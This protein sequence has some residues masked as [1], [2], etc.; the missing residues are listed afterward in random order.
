VAKGPDSAGVVRLARSVGGEATLGNHDAHLLRYRRAR[1]DGDP[2]GDVSEGI[3]KIAKQLDDDDWAWLESLR[4][5]IALPEHAA[6]VV[7]AGL[8]PGV[9]IDRQKQDDMLTMR[10][11]RGDGTATKRIDEGEPWA[12]LW[13]GPPHVY[14]GHDAV[15]GLQ[16][17]PH[18]TGLDTACVYGGRLSACLLPEREIVSVRARRVYSEP[19]KTIAARTAADSGK[20]K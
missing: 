8:V 16:R 20:K 12:S 9:P 18:A 3:R 4:Y 15:R 17:Y 2:T 13:S 11:I 5:T 1:K 14:F 10:S 19:G 6:L 7:H